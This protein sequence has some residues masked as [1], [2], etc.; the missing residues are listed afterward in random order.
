M[1]KLPFVSV[2]CDL[3]FGASLQKL[4]DVNDDIF[5]D[6]TVTRESGKG[7]VHS[8]VVMLRNGIDS[9]RDAEIFECSEWRYEGS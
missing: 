2:E 9:V 6:A 1:G 4:P 3:S 8:A 7:F 5:D